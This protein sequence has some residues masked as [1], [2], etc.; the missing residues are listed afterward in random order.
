LIEHDASGQARGMLFGRP[1]PIFRTMP[2]ELDDELRPDR[3]HP[4]KQRNR[5]QSRCLFH[6]NPQHRRLP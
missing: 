1:V 6:E 4:D 5:S 2:S 3:H